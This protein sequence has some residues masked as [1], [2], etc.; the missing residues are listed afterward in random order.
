MPSRSMK[1]HRLMEAVKHNP[2]FAA[3]V[4][5]P[6]KVGAD[7]AAADRG[8]DLSKLPARVKPQ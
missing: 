6:Q 7:Y 5:I 8:R 4:G 2:A 1:Q 3:R